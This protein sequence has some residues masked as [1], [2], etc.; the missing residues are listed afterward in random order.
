MQSQ[1]LHT[2]WCNISGQAAGEIQNWSVLGVK[3]L[4]KALTLILALDQKR[5]N[6][7]YSDNARNPP[8]CKGAA[9][10]VTSWHLHSPKIQQ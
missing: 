7:F 5:T 6:A 2:V 9:A 4:T 3:G 10:G 8:G 1:V